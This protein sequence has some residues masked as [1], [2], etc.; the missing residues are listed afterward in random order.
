[1]NLIFQPHRYQLELDLVL[2]YIAVYLAFTLPR[3]LPSRAVTFVS[4]AAMVCVIVQVRISKSFITALIQP[5]DMKQTIEFRT[6][7]WLA[8][9]PDVGRVFATGSIAFWLN[10]FADTPQF[11]GGA[12]QGLPNEQVRTAFRTIYGHSAAPPDA[13][14]ALALLW[15]RAYGIDTAVVGGPNSREYFKLFREPAKFDLI[16]KRIWQSG[17]MLSTVFRGTP[18]PWLTSYA[19]RIWWRLRR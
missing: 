17:G 19:Q 14:G 6:A 3:Q 15:L 11:G 13:N 7:D 16:G 4:L 2:C 12:D 8:H 10:A 1:M 18:L 5:I 9:H